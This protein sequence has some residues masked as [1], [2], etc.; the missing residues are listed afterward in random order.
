VA[1][2]IGPTLLVVALRHWLI[3]MLILRQ[4]LETLIWSPVVQLL[5]AFAL[6]S[7]VVAVLRVRR[8]ASERATQ[9]RPAHS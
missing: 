5:L 2:V 9:P 7:L 1:L 8:C 4:P 6:V 3:G